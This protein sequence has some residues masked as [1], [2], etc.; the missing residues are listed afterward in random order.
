MLRGQS[1]EPQNAKHYEPAG[2]TQMGTLGVTRK[3]VPR[4]LLYASVRLPVSADLTREKPF[5]SRSRVGK[6]NALHGAALERPSS[7]HPRRPVCGY[8]AEAINLWRCAH[9]A[10]LSR[11]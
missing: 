11:C 5:A 2:S 10:A 9:L 6:E 7:P 4:G 3:G 8:S 1:A